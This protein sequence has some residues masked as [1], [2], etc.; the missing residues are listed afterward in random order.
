MAWNPTREESG[1]DFSIL[2]IDTIQ[3]REE[4]ILAILRILKSC[5]LSSA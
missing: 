1:Q 2:R 5:P 4:E 3:A